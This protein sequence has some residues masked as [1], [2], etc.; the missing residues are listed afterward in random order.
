M[1]LKGALLG[2]SPRAVEI[3]FNNRSLKSQVRA[4]H[5]AEWKK[6]GQRGET[7][8]QGMET[9][10]RGMS[11]MTSPWL[12]QADTTLIAKSEI[13]SEGQKGGGQETSRDGGPKGWK[14]LS[15]SP[16]FERW[17]SWQD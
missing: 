14:K 3:G 10:G 12:L 9:G 1:V 5:S 2:I 7:A 13:Q 16:S 17:G 4:P 8:V 15:E 6:Q 11:Q